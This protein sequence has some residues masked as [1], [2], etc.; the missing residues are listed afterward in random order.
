MIL[1][2]VNLNGDR[3]EVLVEELRVMEEID[4]IQYEISMQ[5]HLK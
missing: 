4:I 5:G 1:P 2:V 3:K